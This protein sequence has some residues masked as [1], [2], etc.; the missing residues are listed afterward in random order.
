MRIVGGVWSG[1]KLHSP[2]VRVRPTQDRV[3]QVL[4][5]IL[6][7]RVAG[8]SVLDLYAGSG[9]LG[10]EA[11]SRGA[12]GAVFVEKSRRTCEGLERNLE[13]LGGQSQA[14][15]L[16][17]PV[18]R[19]LSMLSR[20]GTAFGLVLADPPYGN[21]ETEEIL[22]A[23]GAPGSVLLGLEGDLVLETRTTDPVPER[24]LRLIRT[25]QRVIGGTTL[26]FFRLEAAESPPGRDA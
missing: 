24:R 13:E 2:G 17:L 11:L 12:D 5:D 20:E 25:R 8:R 19:A 15:I 16:N 4:F 10:L 26:H 23:F 9:A 6:G 18:V 22:E 1:R 7:P 3:R 14:R 21:T